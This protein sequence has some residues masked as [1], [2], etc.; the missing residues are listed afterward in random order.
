VY[1]RPDTIPITWYFARFLW[2]ETEA[3]GDQVRGKDKKIHGIGFRQL[4]EVRLVA[5]IIV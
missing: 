1:I 2:R 3:A 5:K 4:L